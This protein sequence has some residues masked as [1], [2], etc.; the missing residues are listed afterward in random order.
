MSRIKNPDE[1]KRLS[2]AKDH[3][4]FALE[5][6]KTFRSAWRLKKAQTNR[7]FRR[8]A[9]MAL[10]NPAELE[11]G[12]TSESAVAKPKRSLKKYGVMSLAQS[13]SVRNNKS[14]LRWASSVLEKNPDT[15]DAT[16]AR[17]KLKR[18]S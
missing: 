14:G 9:A 3:R 11:T 15:L 8:A 5:G 13:I 1:K 2:L 4:T 10:A 6:N 16:I 17:K 18:G 12:D 7:L